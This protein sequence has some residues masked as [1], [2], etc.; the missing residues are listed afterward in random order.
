[1]RF[2]FTFIASSGRIKRIKVDFAR[3]SCAFFLLFYHT[4]A[5][6]EICCGL[7][8]GVLAAVATD[9]VGVFFLIDNVL[10]SEIGVKQK[11]KSPRTRQVTETNSRLICW[12]NC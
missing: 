10:K 1:M 8:D 2:G 4:M 11:K 6:G 3:I 12:C 9:A 7:K 5:N